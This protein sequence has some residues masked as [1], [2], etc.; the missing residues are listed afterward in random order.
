M[1]L[2]VLRRLLE[3]DRSVR[4]GEW[5][6]A[7][8]L[9]P[10][11]LGERCVGLI[12][13]GRIGSAVARRLAGFGCEVIGVDPALST[14]D[15]AM[16]VSLNELLDRADVVSLHVPLTPRT[17]S[18]IDA[19]TIRRLREGTVLVNT[20]RGEIVDQTALVEALRDGHLGGAALDVFEQE[21]PKD[22]ELFALS[23]VIL[24]PHIAGFS[25]ES[26]RELTMQA[27]ESVVDVLAGRTAA[28][29]VNPK[30]L[31][32]PRHA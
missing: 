29:I 32:H 25:A 22:P 16:I 8:E 20:S 23:N 26:I 28:G 5:D 27:I 30:A 2:A 31:A 12:G 15:A 18:L 21:P 17:R 1:M 3:N 19:R 14:H 11:S 9:T 4:R 13:V 6:R 10:W 7:G 24:S